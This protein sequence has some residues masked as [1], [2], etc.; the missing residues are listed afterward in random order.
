VTTIV[1][2]VQTCHAC[3]SQ[4]DAWTDT[5]QYLYLR[6]RYGY[7][8]VE[9]Q[10]GPDVDTWSHQP[11]LVASFQDEDGWAGEISLEEFCERAG[12]T[13]KGDDHG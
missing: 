12:L 1:K 2:A 4:W 5:G 8:S 13:L 11:T 10:P 6:F 7:G 9:S 3:P